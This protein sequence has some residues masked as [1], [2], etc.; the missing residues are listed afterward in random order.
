MQMYTCKYWK[1]TL[2]PLTSVIWEEKRENEIVF[3]LGGWDFTFNST[4]TF[5]LHFLKL[6]DNL[7]IV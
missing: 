3:G 4:F 2:K 5:C 6:K 1:D 7:R